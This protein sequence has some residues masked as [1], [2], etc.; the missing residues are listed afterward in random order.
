MSGWNGGL[1]VQR[2]LTRYSGRPYDRLMQLILFSL[3]ELAGCFA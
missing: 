2:R 3:G 1:V